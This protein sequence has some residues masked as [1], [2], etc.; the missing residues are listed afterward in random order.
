MLIDDTSYN[1]NHE[2]HTQTARG[3]RK[4]VIEDISICLVQNIYNFFIIHQ[5]YLVQ[6]IVINR[7]WYEKLNLHILKRCAQLIWNVCCF[8]PIDSF[9]LHLETIYPVVIWS[10]NFS[11]AQKKLV[12]AMRLRWPWAYWQNMVP[13]VNDIFL[14]VSGFFSHVTDKRI[15]APQGYF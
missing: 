13:T 11:W 1:M 4:S 3:R 14:S 15:M 2:L 5:K 9:F 6:D 8:L 12:H 7:I 10:T